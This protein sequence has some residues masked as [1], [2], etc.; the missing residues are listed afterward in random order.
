SLIQRMFGF[1]AYLNEARL[2]WAPLVKHE[3]QRFLFKKKYVH[4]YFDTPIDKKSSYAVIKYRN[5]EILDL[6]DK[7]EK[8]KVKSKKGQSKVKMPIK[9]FNIKK[10]KL[11]LQYC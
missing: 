7:H 3:A 9:K 6:L 4:I 8:V 11:D 2:V 10:K 5:N 1:A